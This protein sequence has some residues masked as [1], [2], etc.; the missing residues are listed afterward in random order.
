MRP[1]FRPVLVAFVVVLAISAVGAAVAEGTTGPVWLYKGAE[2]TGGAKVPIRLKAKGQVLFTKSFANTIC[3]KMSSAGELS[4]TN[5]GTTENEAITFSECHLEGKTLGECAMTSSGA[6]KGTVGPFSVDTVL[7]YPLGGREGTA[8]LDA[9][10]PSPSKTEFFS[11][12]YEGTN[13]GL[14]AGRTGKLVATGSKIGTSEANCGML[15]EVGKIEAGTFKVTAPG[16]EALVGGLSE[17]RTSP[18]KAEVL[19]GGSYSSIT[20]GLEEKAGGGAAAF[21]IVGTDEMETSPLA[22][23]VGW[24]K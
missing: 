1:K 20:C 23:L 8:A 19:K 4:G 24:K 10:A 16:E 15:A 17:S 21:L 3:Q 18:A 9:I 13:C 6:A 12:K 7:A 2:L 11:F 5:P 14:F 22:E